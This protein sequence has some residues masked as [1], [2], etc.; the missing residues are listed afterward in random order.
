MYKEKADFFDAQARAPWAD[1][2]YT[3]EEM[4]KVRRL[5]RLLPNKQ[6]LTL[7]EPGCGT[8]RL[9]VELAEAVAPGGSVMALD[10]SP[11]MVEVAKQRLGRCNNAEVLT[12][13]LESR[14]LPER[15]FDAVVCHQVFPHLNDKPRALERM[16][17]LLKPQG[18]LI[19]SHFIGREEI[20]DVHRKAGTVVEHDLLPDAAEMRELLE[21]GGFDVLELVDMPD[22]YMLS[23]CLKS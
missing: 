5:L 15:A 12:V 7:L 2:E 18:H 3:L 8:G 20:N 6:G 10:I 1:N 13:E 21:A 23:A 16:A 4:E 14:I 9:T 19:I 22:F 17:C 11:R